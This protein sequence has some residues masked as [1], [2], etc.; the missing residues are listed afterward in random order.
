MY[1]ASESFRFT[2]KSQKKKSK[3]N[4]DCITR[5]IQIF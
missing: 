4:Q 5:K 3:K 1:G 2:Y